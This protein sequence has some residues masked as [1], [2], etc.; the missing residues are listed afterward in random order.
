VGVIYSGARAALYAT[1]NKRIGIIGTR[2]TI[3]SRAYEKQLTELDSSVRTFSQA[4][5][6]FVPLVEEGWIDNEVAL[7]IARL[8]L[9]P[10]KRRRIDTLILG[11]THYPLLKGVIQ[12]VMGQG[13]GLID[14][15][16]YVAIEVQRILDQEGLLE[17]SRRSKGRQ[18][19][20]VSDD[21]AGFRRLAESFLTQPI[22][23]VFR[24]D[25]HI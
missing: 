5:S 25:G 7:Q 19:Y 9:A 13:V 22:K 21:A 20:F 6:L 16:Y 8:Y 23:E 10:L 3:Q 18:E 4:C 1:K 15:A 24:F 17:T 11:C 2:A 14:S 12:K